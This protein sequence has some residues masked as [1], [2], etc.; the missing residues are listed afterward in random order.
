MSSHRPGVS[1]RGAQFLPNV[2]KAHGK[3]KAAAG[4]GKGK[5]KGND[6]GKKGSNKPSR[7]GE[8]SAGYEEDLRGV[9]ILPN[10]QAFLRAMHGSR[11][12]DID[13]F[14][15]SGWPLWQVAVS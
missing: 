14:V 2:G 12:R 13:A 5:G 4:T 11:R 15:L 10:W 7:D 9:H 3:A 1:C 6:S 8:V